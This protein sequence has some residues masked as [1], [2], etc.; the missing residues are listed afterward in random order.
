MK[1]PHLYPSKH[2]IPIW[3]TVLAALWQIVFA[4]EAIVLYKVILIHPQPY[5]FY[6]MTYEYWSWYVKEYEPFPHENSLLSLTNILGRLF[7]VAIVICITYCYLHR[8]R[9]RKMI[10]C[11]LLGGLAWLL[12]SLACYCLISAVVTHYRLFMQWIPVEF[13]SLWLIYLLVKRVSLPNS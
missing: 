2:R 13:L 8:E 11:A 7:A 12:T 5:L 1:D 4:I 6:K 9:G 3:A 10:K